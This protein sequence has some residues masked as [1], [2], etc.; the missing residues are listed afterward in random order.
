MIGR[1]MIAPDRLQLLASGNTQQS[2]LIEIKF[3]ADSKRGKGDLHG[4]TLL[5][6]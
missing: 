1:E 4:L 2:L 6:V 3:L 5:L